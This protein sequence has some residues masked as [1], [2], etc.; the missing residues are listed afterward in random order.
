MTP[1]IVNDASCLID[2]RKGGLLSALCEL[3]YRLVVPLPVRESEVLDFS[4][5]DWRL[6]DDAGMITRNLT[7]DEVEKAHHLMGRDPK[8]SANDCFCVVVAQARAG[9]LLTG[10]SLLRRL[11]TRYDL[12]VHGV[13]WVVD[14]V[15]AAGTLPRPVRSR[16]LRIWES[17]KAVFLPQHEIAH[18]LARFRNLPL[19]SPSASPGST[20]SI[21]SV[22]SV[23][24]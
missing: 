1:A 17:D 18:R 5:E 3:P 8:L 20:G 9:I 24:D 15:D 10:D 22:Q 2:L 7:P 4:K 12:R 21:G 23:G 11:A 19:R 6:L 16:A 13:L 14:E